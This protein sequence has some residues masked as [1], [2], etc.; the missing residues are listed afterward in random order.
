[1][2]LTESLTPPERHIQGNG[3]ICVVHYEFVDASGGGF[4]A[5]VELY[6]KIVFET[7]IYQDLDRIPHD[8]LAPGTRAGARNPLII[9]SSKSSSCEL[10]ICIFN[11]CY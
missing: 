4:G 7:G 2:K 1:M 11:D 10:R 6:C 9:K 5:S 8:R 3:R